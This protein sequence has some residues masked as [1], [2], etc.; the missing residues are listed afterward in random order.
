[1]ENED[2]AKSVYRAES[3]LTN[4]VVMLVAASDRIL[5]LLK[6]LDAAPTTL[7]I[8]QQ[9]VSLRKG[10]AEIIDAIVRLGRDLPSFA[11]PRSPSKDDSRKIDPPV[12][13][14]SQIASYVLQSIRAD[15]KLGNGASIRGT[16]R[17]LPKLATELR[18]WTERT[19]KIKTSDVC[20]S[21]EAPTPP[22]PPEIAEHVGG[23]QSLSAAD[24]CLLRTATE[25]LFRAS[26]LAIEDAAERLQLP[27]DHPDVKAD[28]H[29][30]V[31]TSFHDLGLEQ[32]L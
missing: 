18:R 5:A 10:L 7:R 22:L 1:V 15:L 21:L 3:Q 11:P 14:P 6:R 31:F 32:A 2:L 23:V 13:D 26:E 9:K 8:L 12:S 4:Q 28:A 20:R 24:R 25:K 16:E 27:M 19:S 30:Q 17:V 29:K